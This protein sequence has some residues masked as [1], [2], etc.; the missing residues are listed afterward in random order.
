MASAIN[1]NEGRHGPVETAT[2]HGDRGSSRFIQRDMIA[3]LLDE[4]NFRN[5]LYGREG[6]HSALLVTD[7]ILAGKM[8]EIELARLTR[9]SDHALRV[10][11]IPGQQPRAMMPDGV[12]FQAK[13]VPPAT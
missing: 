13:P 6:R 1:K 5:R 12:T 2:P 11:V 10:V 8:N 4:S 7:I 3:L 9:F